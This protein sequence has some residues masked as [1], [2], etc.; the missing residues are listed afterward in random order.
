M[1]WAF[2]SAP[3]GLREQLFLISIFVYVFHIL[4]VHACSV[5]SDM[6]NCLW[7]HGL[8]PT[9]LLCPW[10]SSGKNTGVGCHALLQGIF[11][12]QGSSP[13]LLHLLHWQ[14]GSLPL[15]PPGKP[16][17]GLFFV[18]KQRK[19]LAEHKPLHTMGVQYIWLMYQ[20]RKW[21]GLWFVLPERQLPRALEI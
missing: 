6:S 9:S 17:Y 4:A 5:I 20:K 13:Q 14:A 18:S 12:T 21:K 10:N 15:A 19:S 2:A 8:Q 1:P 11:P 3:E 16:I 7:S